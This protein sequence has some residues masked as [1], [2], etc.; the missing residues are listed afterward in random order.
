MTDQERR[1]IANPKASLIYFSEA[2]IVRER[3]TE[4]DVNPVY[5]VAEDEEGRKWC[6]DIAV[7]LMKDFGYFMKSKGLG[8]TDF[9]RMIRSM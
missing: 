1:R 9:V 4:E 8:Y 2:A 5:I 7:M 6:N 3:E